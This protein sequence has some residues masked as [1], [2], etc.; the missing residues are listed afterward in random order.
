MKKSAVRLL[1]ILICLV[2]VISCSDDDD[3]NLQSTGVNGKPGKVIIKYTDPNSKDTDVFFYYKAD[4]LTRTKAIKGS[5]LDFNYENNEL[6]SVYTS[7]EDKEVAD[8]HGS[9]K[10]SKESNKIIIESWGEPSSDLFRWELELDE[11]N[12]PVKITE[13]GMYSPSGANGELSKV[14]DGEYYSV[15]TYDQTTKNLVKQIVYNIGT[16]NIA[17]TYEY[18]Y[19]NNPGAISKIYL[20][21][22]YYA[23]KAY[24]NREYRNVYNRLFFNYTNNI[25]KEIVDT[26]EGESIVNYSYKYNKNNTPVS[27]GSD[28]YGLPAISITY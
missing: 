6:K 5:V 1:F 25:Q 16:S 2:F 3:N 18:E 28:I 17:A 10:F 9:T 15:F 11:N 13:M 26:E 4:K 7:P 12:I 19:D 21:L 14:R 27:M 23:Y 24:M 20:P 22:W 8:G